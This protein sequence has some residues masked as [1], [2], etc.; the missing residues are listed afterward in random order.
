MGKLDQIFIGNLRNSKDTSPERNFRNLLNIGTNELFFLFDKKYYKEFY[1]VAM[2]SP[3]GPS[4]CVILE[5]FDTVPMISN[6][7]CM[8]I[9]FMTFLHY[10]PLLIIRINLRST[11]H[12]I[13]LK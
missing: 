3:L 13:I 11:Y 6:L 8:D 2:V 5:G 9:M 1:I 4:L 12:L 7:S 10:F